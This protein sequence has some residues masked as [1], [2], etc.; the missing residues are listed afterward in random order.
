M[1][2]FAHR[3]SSFDAPENTIE[4]FQ[5]ARK[6]GADGIEL[7]VR[8]SS[9]G[10]LVLAHDATLSDGTIVSNVTFDEL[11]RR[12]PSLATLEEALAVDPD[13]TVNVEIKNSPA[14]P[15]YAPEALARRTVELC[16]GPST[17]G[18][19]LISSFDLDTIAAVR[20]LNGPDTAY[21]VFSVEGQDA[22]AACRAGGHVA[23]HPWDAGVDEATV[24][25]CLAA[26]LEM[27]VWTVD[28]PERIRTLA[29]WNVS[30]VVT[31]RP[32]AAREALSR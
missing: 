21:L 18:R 26:G 28:D 25:Q 23:V 22:L 7:D 9:D 30:G 16:S 17:P 4:A 12:E 8:A 24:Q 31:N 29:Q 19:I 32:D 10:V 15:G 13:W 6:H 27:N 2:I 1:F 14:E 3:G 20:R 11:R 5:L